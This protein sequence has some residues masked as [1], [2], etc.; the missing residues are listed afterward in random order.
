MAISSKPTCQYLYDLNGAD[1]FRF[2]THRE[3]FDS[4]DASAYQ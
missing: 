2:A 1:N 4:L 3:L